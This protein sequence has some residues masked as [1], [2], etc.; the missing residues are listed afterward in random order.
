MGIRVAAALAA[1]VLAVAVGAAIL[2]VHHGPLG[3]TPGGAD[4]NVKA[5]QAMISSN[6]NAM[7]DQDSLGGSCVG[8]NDAGCETILNAAV[9]VYQKWVSDLTA[10]Q[11]PA[12]FAILDGMLRRHLNDKITELTAIVAYQK[13]GNANGFTLAQVGDFYE[14]EWLDPAVSTIEGSYPRVAGSY[15]DAVAVAKQSLEGCINQAPGP[16]DRR[17]GARRAPTGRRSRF[18]CG[19]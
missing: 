6:Y 7:V 16:A 5:Y 13:T 12:R 10:F 2:A 11:T 17:S 9:P 19:S 4:P 15:T 14:R 18:A 1:A 3:S 8:I